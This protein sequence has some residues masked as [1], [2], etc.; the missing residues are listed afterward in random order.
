MREGK[1]VP[2]NPAM[3]I[4]VR[5]ASDAPSAPVP[6]EPQRRAGPRS[7]LALGV[8]EIEFRDGSLVRVDGDV[9]LVSLRRVIAVMRE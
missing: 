3:F 6:M 9:N 2:D 4:P 7:A 8:I 1:L 5:I